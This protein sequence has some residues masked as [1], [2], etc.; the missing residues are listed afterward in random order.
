MSFQFTDAH[1]T[2]YHSLGYTV[3][4]GILPPSL[5][6][7][8][9]RSSDKA[10]EIGRKLHGPQ[11]QRLQPIAKYE[12]EQQPFRDYA[13]LPALNDAV[14]RLLS[15]RHKFCNLGKPGTG[16]FGVCGVLLEPADLPYC[17]AWHR[18]WRDNMPGVPLADWDDMFHDVDCFNQVNCA[19]YEDSCTWVVPG[20]HLRRDTSSE[21]RRFPTRPVEGPALEGKSFEERERLCL[22]Y[23]QSMPGAVQL[24]LNA[25]DFAL[26]RNTLWHLGSYLPYRKRATLHDAVDTPRYAEW[27]DRIMKA[28]EE[29]KKAGQVWENPN[30]LAA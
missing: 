21:A 7:D 27:R 15:K 22:E 8:L 11:C 26:Y 3:F 20:S 14:Q 4:R 5:I 16:D 2:D 24:F 6:G 10:R 30:E 18:D 13:E 1:V 12:V 29:R 25:G 9:R 23:C 17:T 28:S 19:L